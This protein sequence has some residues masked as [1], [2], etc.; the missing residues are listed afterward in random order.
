M[1]Y[2]DMYLVFKKVNQDK[3]EFVTA[4]TEKYGLSNVQCFRVYHEC[5]VWS[6][7]YDDTSKFSRAVSLW[8]TKPCD[9]WDMNE[10]TQLLQQPPIEFSKVSSLETASKIRNYSGLKPSTIDYKS[11]F[12]QWKLTHDDE[13]IRIA[14][15]YTAG[16]F[17]LAMFKGLT[18]IATTSK[19]KMYV[20][21]CK[22]AGLPDARVQL[23]EL[24][25]SN[26]TVERM[27]DTYRLIMGLPSLATETSK[28]SI[29]PYMELIEQ[30]QHMPIVNL[31]RLITSKGLNANR[32]RTIIHAARLTN[33]NLKTMQEHIISD[34]TKYLS[35]KKN[36]PA[37]A[38]DYLV[39]LGYHRRACQRVRQFSI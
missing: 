35:R 22:R 11:L 20:E 38:V 21:V 26:R 6:G 10:F 24:G 33:P 17:V 30:N 18:G 15:G 28:R 29:A 16:R 25:Y 27:I 19:E 13:G 36:D 9:Q 23:I 2:L 31:I 14:C 34:L 32:A 7:Q 3:S 37:K 5:M 8:R 12:E 1:N 39:G 4:I